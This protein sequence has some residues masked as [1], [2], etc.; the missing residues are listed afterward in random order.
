LLKLSSTYSDSYQEEVIKQTTLD[1]IADPA[2]HK[3]RQDKAQ[4]WVKIFRNKFHL[5]T[6]YTDIED[7]IL[8][9]VVSK[10]E[11]NAMICL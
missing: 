2:E 4:E 7:E 9:L 8:E 5:E 3:D 11:G 6:L 10:S 1:P